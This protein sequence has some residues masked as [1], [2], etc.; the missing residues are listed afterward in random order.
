MAAVAVVGGS[1]MG[2][3][4]VCGMTGG[5][6]SGEGAVVNMDGGPGQPGGMAIVTGIGGGDVPLRLGMT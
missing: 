1:R 2:C 4:F 3:G 6:C 5:A